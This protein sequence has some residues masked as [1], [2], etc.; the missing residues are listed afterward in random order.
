MHVQAVTYSLSLSLALALALNLFLRDIHSAQDVREREHPQALE[1]HLLVPGARGGG[2]DGGGS[3]PEAVHVVEHHV[4][5]RVEE[6]C[7]AADGE[8]LVHLHESHALVQEQI[9]HGGA[10]R[11]G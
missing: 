5:G 10:C 6:T 7:G 3:D 8:G 9:L 11:N 2:Q 4:A 1:E